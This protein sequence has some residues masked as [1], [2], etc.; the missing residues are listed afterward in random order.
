MLLFL[1][2]LS[3]KLIERMNLYDLELAFEMLV[4]EKKLN[5]AATRI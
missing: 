4:M 5:M 3:Y 1:V 2:H